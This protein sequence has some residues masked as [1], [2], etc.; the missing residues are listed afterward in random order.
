MLWVKGEEA[1]KGWAPLPE[2]RKIP[3]EA[4]SGP[5]PAKN[6]IR[7]V[8]RLTRFLVSSLKITPP[9]NSSIAPQAKYTE[10][11]RICKFNLTSPTNRKIDCLI[12]D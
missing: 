10:I 7:L 1:A 2:V 11:T 6:S 5:S 12:L 4:K 8:A 3:S 9:K